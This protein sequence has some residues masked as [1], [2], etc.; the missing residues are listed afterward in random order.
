M[1]RFFGFV[2]KEIYHIIRD[3]RTL[4]ILFGMPVIQ[5][6]LFGYALTN[7]IK[8]ARIA[9][10]DPS[11]DYVT[12]GIINKLVSSG[13]FILQQYLETPAETDHVFRK[14]KTKEVLIFESQFSEKLFKNGKASVQIIGDATDPNEANVLA[15][16]TSAI[17]QDYQQELNKTSAKPVLILP[18]VKM[19]FNP[20]LKGVY[21][22]IPG[23][24]ALIL[25][26][27]SALM[28]SI[29]IAREK[30]LGT[31]EV[32]LAS[33][34]NPLQIILGKVLPYLVLSFVIALI[35][36][37][38]GMTVFGVPVKGSFVLLLGECLLFTLMSLSL[39]ILISTVANSQQTAMMM[40]M[41]G[42][43]LPTVL[44]SGFVFPIENMPVILQWL[45][46]L[47]PARWFI[48]IIKGIM[49]KGV[50]IEFLWKETGII[51]L[52]T[53][54]FIW[55]SIRKFKIRLE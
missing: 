53:L 38:L 32:L 17:L 40:S 48:A 51:L 28:T 43:M 39:G 41:F 27:I 45:S 29:S 4:V 52:M 8:N 6:F 26:L 21:M 34:L 22:F 18:E 35:I 11:K 1:N 25:I 37:G 19:L 23:L 12:Q 36:L 31:M 47:S 3:Q 42:L 49:H 50:G 14:T 44:L 33:P 24:M 13:Y 16:Y 54:F 20:G 10:Y 2:L 7:E 15:N 9:V 5:I 46:V 55:Q 30:E